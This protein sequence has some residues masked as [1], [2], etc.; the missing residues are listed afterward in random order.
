MDFFIYKSTH[1]LILYLQS[2]SFLVQKYHVQSTSFW[3]LWSTI[4]IENKGKKNW[5][6]I[7]HFLMYFFYFLIFDQLQGR[8]KK[9]PNSPLSCWMLIGPSAW[10]KNSFF[11][12]SFPPLFKTSKGIIVGQ[13]NFAWAPKS[14][15]LKDFIKKKFWAP[16]F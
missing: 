12:L 14:Q 6:Q 2:I 5:I 13:Q 8:L 7:I 11:L 9:L 4:Y 10:A 16:P 15:K 3:P 1:F